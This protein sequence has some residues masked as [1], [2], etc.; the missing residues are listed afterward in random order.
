[1]SYEFEVREIPAQPY[2]SSRAATT[3]KGIGETIAV[4]LKE[5]WEHIEQ[6]DG[7]PIGPPFTAYTRDNGDDDIEIEAGIPLDRPIEGNERVICQMSP[8]GEAVSIVHIGPFE[9]LRG[10][11]AA[12]AAWAAKNH[13]T[14]HGANVHVYWTDP[15]AVQDPAKWKTEVVMFLLPQRDRPSPTM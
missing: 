9:G 6:S 5:V 14:P 10:A 11:D 8:G 15:A 7:V 2:A 12:L 13:R 4:L 3:R 1:M